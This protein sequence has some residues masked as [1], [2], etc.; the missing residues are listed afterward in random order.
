MYEQDDFGFG[1]NLEPPNSYDAEATVL[2]AVLINERVMPLIFSRIKPDFF[3][4]QRI[5]SLMQI[6]SSL[7]AT[8]S[9]ADAITVLNKALSAGIF[10]TPQEGR[11]YLSGIVGGVPSVANTESYCNIIADKYYTRALLQACKEITSRITAPS[12]DAE[13]SGVLIDYA[14]QLIYN[15]R[16]GREVKGLVHIKE[17]LFNAYDMLGKISGPD[18]EQYLGAKSGFTALDYKTSGLNNSDLIIL[19]ARPGM[20]KTSFALNIATQVAKGKKE[21]AVFSLEMSKEQLITRMLS[22]EARIESNKLRSGRIT[23]Q[24]WQKLAHS[25]DNLSKL[26]M[27]VDDTSAVTVQDIKSKARKLRNLGLIVI[28]YLQLMSST[29]KTDNMN[30]K[31][32]EITRQLKIMAKELNV[33]VI[34]LSQLSRSAEGRSDKRPMLSD[35]RDSGAIEQDADIVYFLYNESYYNKEKPTTDA[36]CIVAKNRHGET[37]TV[38]LYWDGQFTRFVDKET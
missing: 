1:A 15:I 4:N 26:S 12:L 11:E 38:E 32:S 30:T 36:E 18:R 25:A 23:P 14:E 34:L 27:Y 16:Q 7:Y 33:P 5:R 6:I 37:G 24:D 9:V 10:A 29:L 20:G 17:I 28:D 22:S 21:V 8:A 2:G 35:L 31:V 19:A 3:Y 13:D